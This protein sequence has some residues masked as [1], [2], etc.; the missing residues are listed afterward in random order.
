MKNGKTKYLILWLCMVILSIGCLYYANLVQKGFG[1]INITVDSFDYDG[2]K[3]VY[4]LYKPQDVSSANPAP[5]VLLLH[6]YQNDKDTCDAYCIELA[7]RGAVV[8]AIDEFGHG[9]TTLSMIKRGFVNH[10]VKTNYGLD[11][12]ADGT[13]KKMGGSKRY[14][15]LLNFSNLS[16]FNDHYSKDSDGNQILDSSMGGIAAYKYLG[17]LDY[18]DQSRMGISGHS[19]GTWASWT[20]AAA[21]W[22]VTDASG[23]DITPK[24]TVLQAGELFTDKAYD[25]NKYKF[26]NV[27]L[28]TAKYDEFNYFRDYQNT[29]TDKLLE[30]D[31]RKNF[32]GISTKGSWNTTY[33][34]F[35]DGSARR[36]ELLIT[37]HRLVT[38]A[39]QAVTST[40]EWF[41]QALNFSSPLNAND[42]IYN[43]KE[44]AQL[45]ATLLA[46]FSMLPLA[47][48]LLGTSLF[49]N[50][51]DQLPDRPYHR[52]SFGKLL[53][54]LLVT[55]LLSG[56]TYP[57]MTQLGHAL[58]PLPEN[59]F[60]MT[61]GNGFLGWYG[62]LIIIMLVMTIVTFRRSKKKGIPM[63]FMDLGFA[64]NRSSHR[65]DFAL[66]LQSLFLAVILTGSVYLI[67][68]LSELIFH[69]DLRFIWPFFRSFNTERALQFAVYLPVYIL[70]FVLSNSRVLAQMP[71]KATVKK[72]FG[73]FM[74][75][76]IVCAL[77]MVGGVLLIVL[78]EYIPFFGGIG[79][80][81]DLLFGSTFG[82]PFMSLMIVFV[83]QVLVFSVLCTYL[84]RRT[85]NVFL[86]GITV[87][88]LACWIITGGSAML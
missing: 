2:G 70:F 46:L 49:K 54:G 56:L 71:I 45:A 53:T 10:T 48:L 1:K 67:T 83:P 22:N 41:Q 69:L 61:I 88:I 11:S 25:S 30:S 26:N 84:Y 9:S 57:F 58:L 19:M 18:V 33:G 86:S 82:G 66:L 6:G 7:R 20:V 47:E 35:A 68:W 8:M 75:N 17:S 12:E 42:H 80:G 32:L 37:N 39:N 81:A 27:M 13:F 5:A 24:A 77:G 52:K 51:A 40:V 78:L 85:G 73:G 55:M 3:I 15:V 65:F 23:K 36:C 87:A 29:V 76:W 44:W 63:D 4:K 28:I 16:F 79:P 74:V 31:L 64:R 59:I 72:G 21:Y 60:R 50:V 62:L 38:H 14:R 34:N 43:G